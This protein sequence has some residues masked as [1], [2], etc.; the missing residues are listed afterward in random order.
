MRNKIIILYI[1]ILIITGCKESIKSDKN[2]LDKDYI[3]LKDSVE[4][5]ICIKKSPERIISFAPN[6]TEIIFKLGGG[7]KLIG[8]TDFCDYPE[9]VKNIETVGEII[10]PN[11]EKI[12]YLKPDLIIASTHFQKETLI[13]LNKLNIKIY[14]GL[15]DNNYKKLYKTISDI[16]IIID[17][18]NKANKLIEYMKN[19]INDIKNKVAGL[20]K[21]NV[22]YMLSFGEVGDFTAGRDTFISYLINISGGSNIADEITGW[23]YSLERLVQKN[24]DIIIC[25]KRSYIKDR[26]KI[27]PVYNELKAVVNNNV[28][29]IDANIIERIGPRNIEAIKLMSKIFHPDIIVDK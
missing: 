5:E 8:R 25:S 16:G 28:Y 17:E 6:M 4:R 3:L 21:P 11:I 19:N 7:K 14:I 18:V 2:Y 29:E 24:P 1:L 10:N 26:L 20:K 13:K 27:T 9:D 22:Y 15:I 23:N 12:I